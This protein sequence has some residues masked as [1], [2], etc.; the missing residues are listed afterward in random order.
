MKIE[1]NLYEMI[2]GEITAIEFKGIIYRADTKNT[3]IE[4]GVRKIEFK[5]MKRQYQGKGSQFQVYVKKMELGARFTEDDFY[6]LYPNI[7]AQARGRRKV[8]LYISKLIGEKKL[9]QHPKNVLE[10]VKH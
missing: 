1:A 4:A 6:K 10:K 3:D 7:Q 8:Q 9:V 2:K 5:P